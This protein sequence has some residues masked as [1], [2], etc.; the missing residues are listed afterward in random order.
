MISCFDLIKQLVENEET[1]LYDSVVVPY[2]GQYSQILD[3][4]ANPATG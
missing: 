2:L 3:I 4:T 1:T